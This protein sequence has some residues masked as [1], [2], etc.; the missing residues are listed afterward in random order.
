MKPKTRPKPKI[1]PKPK[2]RP[3]PKPKPV[4]P[5][6]ISEAPVS[7]HIPDRTSTAVVLA[8]PR[9]LDMLTPVMDLAEAQRRLKEFQQFIAGYLVEGIDQD[10]GIIP[11]TPRRTLFQ[12]GADKLIEVYGLVPK[13]AILSKTIN[14]ETNLFDYEV[15]VSLLRGDRVVGMGLGS[16][17]SFESKYRFRNAER[18]CPDCGKPTIIKGRPEYGGGWLCWRKKDGCGAT[19][20]DEDPAIVNQDQGKVE[21]DNMID[22]KNTVLKMAVKRAKVAATIAATRS[23]GIFTQDLDDNVEPASGAAA[24]SSPP[25][26]PA[27][28]RYAPDPPIPI[29]SMPPPPIAFSKD[30]DRPARRGAPPPKAMPKVTQGQVKRLWTIAGHAGWSQAQVY[31]VVRHILQIADGVDITDAHIHEIAQGKPY[32]TI[33]DHILPAGPGEFFAGKGGY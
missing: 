25:P 12:P 33:C 23:S 29:P 14:Y 27:R 18:V 16:C 31:S 1:Q 26:N 2:A 6:I 28:D 30:P 11:G 13:I 5:E 24:P 3:K 9:S 22:Q 8:H 17:S 7:Q 21:N 32:N 20:A 4:R 19:F 10:Y 15:E